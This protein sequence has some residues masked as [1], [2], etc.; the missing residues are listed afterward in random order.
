MIGQEVHIYSSSSRIHIIVRGHIY[1]S[2]KTLVYIHSSMRTVVYMY[3]SMKTVVYKCQR[4]IY[5]KM[6]T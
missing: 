3:S 5:S 4:D 1:S 6:R 2:M